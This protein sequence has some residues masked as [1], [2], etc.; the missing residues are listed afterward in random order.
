MKLSSAGT[1]LVLALLRVL[2]SSIAA[3][4]AASSASSAS[5]SC[6]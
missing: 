2:N 1:N 3:F 4:L 5:F 6:F